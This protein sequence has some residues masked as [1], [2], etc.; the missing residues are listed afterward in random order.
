M[1]ETC[2]LRNETPLLLNGKRNGR[3]KR[4]R[5]I[6]FSRGILENAVQILSCVCPP[7]RHVCWSDFMFL[8]FRI[9]VK[10][11]L[12]FSFSLFLSVLSVR[13]DVRRRT[14]KGHSR[15][16]IPRFARDLTRT[17]RGVEKSELRP[18]GATARL[19]GFFVRNVDIRIFFPPR[20]QSPGN[21]PVF[22]D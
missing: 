8:R 13:E 14:R 12:S 1:R 4:A 6:S 11:H 5:E 7:E 22:Y 17:L 16:C 19:E 10:L 20:W 18:N 21:S 2:A 15:E 9:F 3:K